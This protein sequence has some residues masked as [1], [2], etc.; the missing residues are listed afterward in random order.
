[1]K[2]RILTVVITLCMVL[3]L[4]PISAN[5]MSIYVDLTIIGETQLT[6]EVESGDSIDNVKEKIKIETG[7]SETLQILKYNGI[8]LENG[9]TLADYNIQKNSTLELSLAGSTPEG[10]EYSISNNKVTITAYSGSA[11]AITIPSTIENMPVTA[12]GTYAFNNCTGL[13][14]INIPESVVSIEDFAFCNCRSLT[15]IEIPASVTELGSSVFYNCTSLTTIEIPDGIPSLGFSFFQGCT[16]LSSIN[17]PESVASIGNAVFSG[18]TSL[19]S[20]VIPDSVTSIGER[21]FRDCTSLE[22][23]TILGNIP[24][25]GDETFYNCPNLPNITIPNSV[26]NIGFCAFQGCTSLKNI[27]IP[28]DVT[29]I[30][31]MAF[32]NCTS[33]ESITI[34]NNVT[35]IGTAAFSECTSLESIFLPENLSLQLYPILDATTQVEYSFDSTKDEVT[36]TK[37]DLGGDKASVDIPDTIYDYPVVA[38]VTSE[39][40]K[41]GAHTCKGGTATCTAKALCS[42]CGKEYGDLGH[43]YEWQSKNGQYWKKCKFCGDETAKKD[44]PTITING[45]DSVSMTEDY[46]FSFTLPEGATDPAYGY[47]FGT[48]GELGIDAIIENNEAHCV[49]R[50][51]WYSSGKKSFEVYAGAKTADGFEFYV[52][53]TVSFNI[54]AEPEDTDNNVKPPKAGDNSHMT[55]WVALFFVGS[56]LLTVTGVFSKKKKHSAR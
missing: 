35:R 32:Q 26:T 28:S 15:D 29:S 50:A 16:S 23:V 47:D 33:L 42:L 5:A 27:T 37:I 22:S 13:E 17:I 45:A 52:S 10:F 7:Y 48:K 21:I 34:P 11:I 51:E 6:L 56:G 31:N 9:R 39:Q 46:K 14:S 43:V 44:I 18:C 40:P 25:I 2:K 20:I 4:V 53:K 36:I 30:G 55:L 12:I 41:V 8:V 3:I 19:K 49:V 1:M 38:V 24:S 54:D